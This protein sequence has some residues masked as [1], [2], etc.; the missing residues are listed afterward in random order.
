MIE[1]AELMPLNFYKKS[2]FT[3]GYQGMRYRI[4]RAED[5]EK[6]EFLVT[7]WPEPYN[8]ETTAE[9]EKE[10]ERFD[11]SE[12]GREKLTQWLNRKYEE[13]KL[14]WSEALQSAIRREE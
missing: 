7:V 10:R 6:Q 1:E 14:R 5:G 3:G 9:E 11:F 8:Y 13:E 2:P 12:D 4:E